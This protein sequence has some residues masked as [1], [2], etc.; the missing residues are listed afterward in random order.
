MLLCMVAFWRESDSASSSASSTPVAEASGSIT[1]GHDLSDAGEISTS[2]DRAFPTP[3]AAQPNG[4]AQASSSRTVAQHHT[5]GAGIS[6]VSLHLS[7][8]PV[9]HIPAP[10]ANVSHTHP[11]IVHP[12]SGTHLFPFPHGPSPTD[13]SSDPNGPSHHH[14]P[15]PLPPHHSHHNSQS[16]VAI[17]FEVIGAVAGAFLI[18]MLSR[19][20]WSWRRTP[21]HDR[22]ETLLSRHYLQRE[23]Q[24]RERTELERRIWRNASVQRPPPPP[25]QPAPAYDAVAVEPCSPPPTHSPPPAES[26]PYGP[27][28]PLLPA[29]DSPPRMATPL[30]AHSPPPTPPPPPAHTPP[31]THTPRFFKI[32]DADFE[33]EPWPTHAA[34]TKH[35]VQELVSASGSADGRSRCLL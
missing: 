18:F 29:E 33:S 25:Y 12:T 4:E 14:P 24:E 20:L 1:P 17:A 22:I 27:A 8:K 5:A 7:S 30:P 32:P 34:V 28:L 6:H 26:P 31:P 13:P 11:V 2:A 21:Q 15:P 3:A 19:C 23:M 16:A 10:T 9:S 35:H